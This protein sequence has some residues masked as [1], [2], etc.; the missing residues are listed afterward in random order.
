MLLRPNEI[1]FLTEFNLPVVFLKF[2]LP[3]SDEIFKAIWP[4]P[5][6][7]DGDHGGLERNFSLLYLR[8]LQPTL[9]TEIQIAARETFPIFQTIVLRSTGCSMG[10]IFCL[11]RRT[12]NV[13][14]YSRCKKKQIKTSP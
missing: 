6:L 11:I 5:I 13:D 1:P 14:F 4:M 8:Q 7:T 2:L 10:A 9:L 3:F 12:A